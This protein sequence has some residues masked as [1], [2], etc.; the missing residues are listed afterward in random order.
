MFFGLMLAWCWLDVGLNDPVFGLASPIFATRDLHLFSPFLSAHDLTVSN[1]T[2][3]KQT[4]VVQTQDRVNDFALYALALSL[5]IAP[6]RSTAGWRAGLIV[7]ALMVLFWQAIKLQKFRQL[8]EV[9]VKERVVVFAVTAWVGVLLIRA[10][11]SSNVMASLN[12]WKGDVLSP[13]AALVVGYAAARIATGIR[14]IVIALFVGILGLLV[15]IA[16][17]PYQQFGIKTVPLYGGAGAVSAWIVA[18]AALLPV[19]W[20]SGRS[21]VSHVTWLITLGALVAIGVFSGSRMV[22][23]CFAVLVIIWGGCRHHI[24]A[25]LPQQ[26]T[27]TYFDFKSVGLVLIA[28]GGCFLFYWLS[29]GLRFQDD[30]LQVVTHFND[31]RHLIYQ[32]ASTLFLQAPW[33][34]YGYGRDVMEP[35]M[36]AQFTLPEHRLLFLQ[37][38]NVVV[39][40]ALQAGVPGAFAFL[41]MFAALAWRFW[42]LMRKSATP[43]YGICGLMLVAVVFA[44]NMTD[45]F[46]IRQNAILFFA[47][48]GLL[49]AR[50]TFE[51]SVRQHVPATS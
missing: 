38:H 37:A 22:W 50:A 35:L 20:Y 26:K 40:Q 36:V 12:Q 7:L 25:T 16:I 34:G 33:W 29:A 27:L 9:L 5:L 49:L 4:Q 42:N 45:D 18:V 51:P 24:T 32:A 28:L 6:F 46:F 47:A 31:H 13:V 23:P 43:L 3:S 2:V 8:K 48:A 11:T 15:T 1:L 14:P 17:N 44:R 30:N 10:L 39:N 19:A 21:T 41:F